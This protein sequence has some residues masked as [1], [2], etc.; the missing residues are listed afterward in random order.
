MDGIIFFAHG[1]SVESA[2]QAVRKV[3]A[4]AARQSGVSRFE[5][6]FLDPIRPTLEQPPKS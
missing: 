6:G 4:D 5:V 3:A 2:N 1:S